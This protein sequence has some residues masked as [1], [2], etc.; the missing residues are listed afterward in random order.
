ME[1]E[2]QTRSDWT[3]YKGE[4]KILKKR[5]KDYNTGEKEFKREKGVKPFGSSGEHYILYSGFALL[6]SKYYLGDGSMQLSAWK[7][8]S[9][10]STNWD[11][12]EILG[13]SIII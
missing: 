11:I 2:R 5:K 3:L 10:F 4:E 9:A 1:T 8:N 7:E 6:S 13:S 12:L